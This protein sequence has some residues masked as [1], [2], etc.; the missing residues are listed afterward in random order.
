MCL[1][2]AVV[3]EAFRSFAEVEVAI[4]TLK[5]ILLQE[6]VTPKCYLSK[7]TEDIKCSVA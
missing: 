3:E 6:K 5:N 7:S 2:W 1:C 4:N